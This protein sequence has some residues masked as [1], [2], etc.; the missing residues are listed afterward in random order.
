MKKIICTL[1]VITLIAVFSTMGY[2]EEEKFP[3]KPVQ[4]IV[5]FPP[6]GGTD[7]LFRT[8]ADGLTKVMNVPVNVV[9]RPGAGGIIGAKSVIAAK[10][11]GYTILGTSISSLVFAPA[12]SLKVPY[13]V[14]NDFE[15]LASIAYQPKLLVV[16]IDSEFKSLEDVVNAA[17]KKPGDLTCGTAGVGTDSHF[18]LEIFKHAAGVDIAHMPYGGGGEAVASLLGGHISLYMSGTTA[19]KSYTKAGRMRGLAVS[20]T[21]VADFPG[22]P[23]FSEKGYPQVDV[24]MSFFMMGPPSLSPR[25]AEEW[26]KAIVRVMEMPEVASAFKRLDNIVDLQT[27]S[28][29]I[30][31]HL[32]QEFERYSKL[33]GELGIK[34]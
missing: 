3:T 30:R 9:N 32:K 16:K 7:I 8:L 33:A 19:V 11:D 14:G 24:T 21:R 26:K 10:N 6:G 2:S 28:P 31:S 34:E 12:A 1:I 23:S 17:K 27:D 5:P 25:V 4:I 22:V 20:V 15:P 29:K 18:A 13:D